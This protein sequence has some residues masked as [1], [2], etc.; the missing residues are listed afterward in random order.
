MHSVWTFLTPFIAAICNCDMKSGC[1]AMRITRDFETPIM[2]RGHDV[3]VV[4]T[5]ACTGCRACEKLCPFEAITHD[6]AN[7][8]VG[9]DANACYGCGICRSACTEDALRLVDREA[10][11]VTA[12]AALA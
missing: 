9:I 1:M 7:R 10:S 5:H 12:G 8:R 2:L 6:R 4:D 11:P 3:A